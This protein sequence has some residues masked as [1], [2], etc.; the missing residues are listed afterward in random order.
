M[1][2]R[3]NYL[4]KIRGFYESD[5]IKIITGV[6]RCGKSV[7]LNQIETEIR[8]K[9]NNVIS[10]N[11][12]DSEQTSH[13]KTCDDLIKY[14][15][16]NKS[17]GICYLFFDEIQFLNDWAI[18]VRT[19]RLKDCSIFIS[20]SNSKLLSGEFTKEL[21]GRY[22]AFRIKTFVYREL[23]EYATMLNKE[24]SIMDY[25]IWG[26]FPKRLEFNNK[27]DEK[28]YII[29]IEESIVYKDLILRYNIR[30]VDLFYKVVNFITMS[31]SRIISVRSIYNYL[32]SNG[33]ECSLTTIGQYLHYLEEA[34]VINKI[35]RYSSKVKRELEYYD[36]YYNDDVVFNSIRQK[37]SK[38][39]ITHNFENI[40]YNELVYMGYELNVYCEKDFEVDFVALKNNKKYYIQVAYSV[41]DE[42]TY[43]RE[44]KPF[45]TLDN[46]IQK[47]L[48]TNDDIDYSTSIVKH[49]KF[50]DFLLMNDLEEKM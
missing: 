22:V 49:I 29:D 28:Q 38:Y 24:I 27:N 45:K 40:V 9:S 16:D 47:I 2:I 11:F 26:G 36:K 23:K 25:I 46:S 20:G 41:A 21:S 17:D 50:K 3:S 6:R 14:V 15:L 31:N 7:L 44:F 34:F 12:E 1:I 5:L 10:L 37:E 39:D 18:A 32:R 4:K 48:I 30:R 35:K 43:E 33:T 13:I 42:T 8:D 19:L